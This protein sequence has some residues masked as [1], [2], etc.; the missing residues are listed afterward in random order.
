MK[1]DKTFRSGAVSASVFLSEREREGDTVVVPSIQFQRGYTD[2][3]GKWHHTNSLNFRDVPGAI[4]VLS[5][6]YEY[7]TLK[8]QEGEVD[9]SS[10]EVAE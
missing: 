4:L 1:P 2:R 5:K 3:E 10:L 9:S 7:L 8:E 6:A